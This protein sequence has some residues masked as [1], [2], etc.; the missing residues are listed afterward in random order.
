MCRIFLTSEPIIVINDHK[1]RKGV[2][3]D[4]E[5]KKSKSEIATS[6]QETGLSSLAAYIAFTQILRGFPGRSSIL[7]HRAR[8]LDSSM[9]AKMVT[10]TMVMPTLSSLSI[11]SVSRTGRR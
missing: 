3:D 7:G 1:V 10:K 5:K 4:K 6:S 9:S 8:W 11:L 2:R